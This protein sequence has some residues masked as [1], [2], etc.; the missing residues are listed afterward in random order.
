[1]GSTIVYP[2]H[3]DC[4][5]RLQDGLKYANETVVPRNCALWR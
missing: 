1:M 3:Y 5:G 2:H 4:A